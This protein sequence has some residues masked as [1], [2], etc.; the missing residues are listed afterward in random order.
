MNYQKCFYRDTVS[1]LQIANRVF[2]N[3]DERQLMAEIRKQV[4]RGY[5]TETDG[6]TDKRT[7]Y[8][9]VR[10]LKPKD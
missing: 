8:S 7:P 9:R 10:L 5:Y 6:R 3:K 2:Y 4:T 1:F